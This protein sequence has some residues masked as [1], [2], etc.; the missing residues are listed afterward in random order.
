MPGPTGT[1]M[2]A[3]VSMASMPRRRP[4]VVDMATA[5]TQLLPRC[6]CTS[7]M[8]TVPSSRF[9]ESAW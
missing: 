4:S 7:A 8:T 3:P 1:V 6:C 2:G 9:T 5:R